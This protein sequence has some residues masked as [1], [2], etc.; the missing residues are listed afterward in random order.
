MLRNYFKFIISFCLFTACKNDSNHVLNNNLTFCDSLK[1]NSTGLI[2]KYISDLDTLCKKSTGVYVLE[3]GDEAMITRAWLCQQATKTIDIQYF[4]FSVDNVGL[5]ACN[6]LLEAANRG[7]KVRILVDDMMVE[8]EPEQIANLNAHP[9]IE[10]K[11]YN[12][13]VNIGKNIIQKLKAFKNDFHKSNQR[14]H[15]KTFIVDEKVV[16]TGGR[17]IAD[18]YF[19]YDH[20]YNFRDR[21]VFLI[22]KTCANVSQSF[23]CFWNNNLSIEIDTILKN[24]NIKIDTLNAYSTLRNYACNPLNFWPQIKNRI[25]NL[26]LNFNN[27]LQSNKF[28]WV[29]SLAFVSDEPGKQPNKNELPK[30][31]QTL[32]NLLKQAKKN[33][34]IES[35]YL[36]TNTETEKLFEETIKRGV[37]IKVLTNSLLSTDNIDAFGGYQRCRENLLNIG[38]KIFEFKPDAKSRFKLLTGDLQKKKNFT[39]IFGL[40]AKTMVIDGSISVIGTF[41]LDPRSEY[42]NTECV[43]VIPNKQIAKNISEFILIDMQKENAWETTK[44]FNPDGLAP[45][46]KQINTKIHH[47][48]PKGIL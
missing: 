38:I 34:L 44:T 25:T 42:L 48:V 27:I 6:Y 14:M 39:P 31:T 10:I 43:T 37:T 11:I 4:I 29:D 45:K 7:V 20:D 23:N 19:D 41:N 15:N 12:S 5:I 33:I 17:N 2:N 8:A 32:A 9:N 16:I 24:E 22:G 18:E 28:H 26:H 21:D 46:L 40:H 47:V 13:G 1:I 3:N 36:I 30:T 35:P